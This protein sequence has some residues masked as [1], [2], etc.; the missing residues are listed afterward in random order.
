VG[1]LKLFDQPFLASSGGGGPNYALYYPIFYIYEK[2]F[3]GGE[4]DFGHAAAAGV[5]YFVIIFVL[6]VVA[7]LT[8]GRQQSA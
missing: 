2:A 7:R 3:G 5:I 8:V 4:A 6:T 1:A